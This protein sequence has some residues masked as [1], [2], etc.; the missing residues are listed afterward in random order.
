MS[1]YLLKLCN[2]YPHLSLE[3]LFPVLKLRQICSIN[4]IFPFL[5][6]WQ[7]D[8]KLAPRPLYTPRLKGCPHNLTKYEKRWNSKTL[9]FNSLVNCDNFGS[10]VWANIQRSR[11]SSSFMNWKKSRSPVRAI[12]TNP[13][14]Q[15]FCELGESLKYSLRPT[16]KNLNI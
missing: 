6:N 5:E 13:S 4:I 8:H 9:I 12:L 15:S 3:T 14:S 10:A 2:F 16:L 1:W 7:F 11:Y